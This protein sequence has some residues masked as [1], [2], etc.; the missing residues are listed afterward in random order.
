MNPKLLNS[1]RENNKPSTV[2]NLNILTLATRMPTTHISKAWNLKNIKPKW[3]DLNRPPLQTVGILWTVA[4]KADRES[5]NIM[6]MN[7]KWKLQWIIFWRIT[8]II[9]LKDPEC[10]IRR[11]NLRNK[12]FKFSLQIHLLLI[13]STILLNKWNFNGICNLKI[14]RRPYLWGLAKSV[15]IRPIIKFIME[16]MDLGQI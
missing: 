12:F 14:K 1:N 4:K 16:L 7:K 11:P 6:L 13:E 8:R 2:A 10:V 15:A 5:K 9:W 3:E